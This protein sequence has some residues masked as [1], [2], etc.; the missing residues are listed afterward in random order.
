MEQK[1]GYLTSKEIIEKLLEETKES[2]RLRDEMGK[3][4]SLKRHRRKKPTMAQT[5][6]R[7]AYAALICILLMTAVSAWV[8]KLSGKTPKLLGR[9]FYIVETGSMIPM[10][11]VGSMIVVKDPKD[12]S[13][14]D[15]GTVV[16]F[17]NGENVITHR[18]ID[19]ITDDS[20]KKEYRTKGDNPIN[21]ADKDLLPPE[22]IIG[23]LDFYIVW[24][25]IS[26]S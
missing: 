19:T 14:L 15:L 3:N 25:W 11:P 5:L 20:G 13:A 21:S 6:R 4:F 1:K 12:A 23:V 16:T 26:S 24:P 10:L 18:I 8:T 2:K 9:Q 22:N 17:K 7:I